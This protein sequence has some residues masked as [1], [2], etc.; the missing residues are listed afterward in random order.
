[1]NRQLKIL[2]TEWSDGMGG[3]E[4]RVLYECKGLMEK[5]HSV[6]LVCREKSRI[7]E[8]AIELGIEVITLPL[9]KPYD[10]ESIIKLVKILKQKKVNIINT[11]SGI[12]SWIGAIAGKIAGVKAI[13]R[14]RHLN[15]PLRRNIFN[16]VH[17]LP[18]L[19][20]TCGENMRK[21]LIENNGFPSE[22][23][24]S[25]PTG[26]E[27][28]FFYVKRDKSIKQKFGLD[29]NNQIII[30]VGILR[31]VKNHELTIIAFSK[32][33]NEF[34][35]AK[36]FL[37]GEGPRKNFLMD[38]VKK[39]NIENSVIFTGFQEDVTPFYSVADVFVLSSKSEGLPQ[40]LLQ[41]MAVG[42]P[43]VAT[44]V[45]GVPEV[46]KHEITGLLTKP[47]DADE[48]AE[49]IIKVLKN[50]RFGEIM[51]EKAKKEIKEKHSL[52]AMLD[53]IESVYMELVSK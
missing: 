12:D 21:N 52:K 8:K 47:D 37:I 22:K 19:F 24:I 17:Y 36:L 1:M 4:K 3:Q 42:V 29:Q 13:V 20:I 39:L 6:T 5:G 33:L 49:N 11:H 32:V 28:K 23:V 34:P 18:D 26:V 25:I 40:A 15:L 53:K 30:N 9:R 16:F 44:A 41:A 45:G 10:I 35:F 46:V 50:P 7:K 38:L 31:L 2:H 27:E 48:L 14:T 51:A 43:V